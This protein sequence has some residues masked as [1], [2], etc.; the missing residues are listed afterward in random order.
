MMCSSCLLYTTNSSFPKLSK[1]NLGCLKNTLYESSY[2]ALFSV[3]CAVRGAFP[4]PRLVEILNLVASAA[5]VPTYQS[6]AS[7]YI[8]FLGLARHNFICA[9]PAHPVRAQQLPPFLGNIIKRR[10]LAPYRKHLLVFV[11]ILL[12]VIV[13]LESC[14]KKGP[15]NKYIEPSIL[16]FRG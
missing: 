5:E 14:E 1:K 8:H 4:Y 10:G 6:G 15:D 9:C 3:P 16:V 11:F 13:H 2:N 7:P 12:I